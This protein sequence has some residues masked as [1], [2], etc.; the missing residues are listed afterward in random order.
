MS[1]P[2]LAGVVLVCLVAGYHFYGGFVARQYRL[3]PEYEP[4]DEHGNVH[5][6]VNEEK[7]AI[8][9][10]FK[11][12]RDAGLLRPSMKGEQLYWTARRGHSVE[13]TPRGREYWWLVKKEK[14]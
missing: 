10:L 1:L 9:Q 12:Y 13:L 11:E 7:V 6:P 14:L 4:E 5:Q 8:A 3:D 2:L